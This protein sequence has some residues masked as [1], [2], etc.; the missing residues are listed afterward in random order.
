GLPVIASDWDGY[1]DTVAHGETGFAIPSAMPGAGAGLELAQRYLAGADTYD[2]Y[3]GNVSQSTAIDVGAATDA[4]VALALDPA[5]RAR[6]GEAG[7]ARARKLF[8]WSVVIAAYEALWQEL[9]AR[10]AHAGAQPGREPPLRGDPFAI[11][12][13]FPTQVIGEATLIERI[14]ADPLAEIARIGASSMNNFTSTILLGREEAARILDALAPGKS[15]PARELL[16]LL[17]DNRRAAF[18]RTI[19]WL[20]KGNIVRIKV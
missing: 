14:A 13:A 15:V 3:I 11:F 8:D 5:L 1:R 20:A 18:F 10:R 16:A 19:G 7:R 12:G 6:M 4:C 9:A 2:R 17:P